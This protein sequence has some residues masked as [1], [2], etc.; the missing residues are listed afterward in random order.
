MF[1]W[2]MWL[3]TIATL[4][5]IFLIFWA[6]QWWLGR[7]MQGLGL[8]ILGKPGAAAR[9]YFWL[10]APGVILHELSHW[11]MA[12]LLFV[13]TGKM[14]LF[15]SHDKKPA[16]QYRY[17][18]TPAPQT[19]EPNADKVVLGYVE[20]AKTDPIRQSL[21]GLAPLVTGLLA[22]IVLAAA[23]NIRG[24]VVDNRN[25][26]QALVAIPEQLFNS[27]RQPLNF[28][29]LYLVFSVSNGM[30]PSAADRKPWLIGFFLPG[31]LILGLSLAGYLRLPDDW[32][33][34]LFSFMGVLAWIFAF[35]AII[36]LLLVV[37][38]VVLEYIIS[39]LRRRRVVYRR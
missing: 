15:R 9:L 21:I 6:L 5:A 35:A 17:R 38:V 13:P 8:L 3:V 1:S 16:R 36:N 28:L 24:V 20:V 33:S 25:L 27:F 14:V 19:V 22:L 39:R 37:I 4:Y 30:L 2:Q 12:K 23:L 18:R 32:I 29:W 10:L 31:A 34:G 26:G 11:L 7:H